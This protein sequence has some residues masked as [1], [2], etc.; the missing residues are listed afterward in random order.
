MASPTTALVFF[1]S[2]S[3][4]LISGGRGAVGLSLVFI[5]G[6]LILGLSVSIFLVFFEPTDDGPS[7]IRH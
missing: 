1:G 5:L 4:S 7:D 2:L 3:L 6:G